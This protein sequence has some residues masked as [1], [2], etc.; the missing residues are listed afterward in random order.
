MFRRNRNGYQ[1]LQPEV[2]VLRREDIDLKLFYR[3]IMIP[4]ACY[5]VHSGGILS[6][7]LAAHYLRNH[8]DEEIDRINNYIGKRFSIHMRHNGKPSNVITGMSNAA[9]PKYL[10]ELES[11]G[12]VI[13]RDIYKNKYLGG[14]HTYY[15]LKEPD[16]EY[17]MKIGRINE[18]E[19]SDASWYKGILEETELRDD[20]YRRHSE[21][22]GKIR[23]GGYCI[24]EL[25]EIFK[26]SDVYKRGRKVARSLSAFISRE[27]VPEILRAVYTDDSLP[28]GIFITW[29]GGVHVRLWSLILLRYMMGEE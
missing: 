9:G 7:V 18:G 13:V 28:T 2:I 17:F 10:L 15:T 24:N 21:F 11:P 29:L 16:F 6:C 5:Y 12:L 8:P 14:I 26:G 19:Y 25:T 1:S 23:R 22:V 20:L 27:D 3:L 4:N